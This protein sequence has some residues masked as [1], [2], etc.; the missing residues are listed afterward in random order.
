MFNSFDEYSTHYVVRAPK[1]KSLVD[2]L[3]YNINPHTGTLIIAILVAVVTIGGAFALS[4]FMDGPTKTAAP[5]TTIE[6]P[7][8]VEGLLKTSIA[9]VQ[10]HGKLMVTSMDVQSISTNKTDGLMSKAEITTAS[11]AKVQYTMDLRKFDPNWIS[12]K[13]TD[14]LITIPE[15]FIQAEILATNTKDIDNSNWWA[16]DEEKKDLHDQNTKINEAQMVT[17]ANAMLEVVRPSAAQE[18]KNIFSIPLNAV[19][20]KFT[21]KVNVG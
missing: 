15:D 7:I 10:K 8:N 16:S 14:I 21:V 20:Q 4:V 13:G 18:L 3:I 12:V 17:Q 11:W 1:K 9:N 6:V 2:Q 19:N 5:T